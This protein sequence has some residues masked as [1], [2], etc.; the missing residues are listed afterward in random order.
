MR[1]KVYTTTVV[2]TALKKQYWNNFQKVFLQLMNCKNFA[3]QNPPNFKE[4]EYLK[5]QMALLEHALIKRTL[6]CVSHNSFSLLLL[7]LV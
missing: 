3:S 4:C 7:F 5:R 2:I 6:L 1:I